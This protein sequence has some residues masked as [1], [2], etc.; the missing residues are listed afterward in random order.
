MK[1]NVIIIAIVVVIVLGIAGFFG[2]QQMT[3]RA[4]TTTRV[5]TQPVRGSISDRCGSWKSFRGQN[6]EPCF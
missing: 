3:A 6:R 5:Q 4:A 2:W 1:R